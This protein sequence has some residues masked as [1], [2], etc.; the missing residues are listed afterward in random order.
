MKEQRDLLRIPHLWAGPSWLTAK[1]LYLES[2]VAYLGKMLLSYAPLS[3]FFAYLL[4]PF[5]TVLWS[6]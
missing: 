1:Y 2:A 5:M 4:L 3:L 6:C